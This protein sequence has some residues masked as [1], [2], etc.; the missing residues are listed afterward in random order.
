[1]A[2]VLKTHEIKFKLPEAVFDQAEVVYNPRTGLDINTPA[3]ECKYSVGIREMWE[4][5]RVSVLLV[6]LMVIA[7]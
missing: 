1:M 4:V 3:E 6:A 2:K 5:A 7:E